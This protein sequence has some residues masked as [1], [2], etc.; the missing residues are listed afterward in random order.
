MTADGLHFPGR[1][2][3]IARLDAAIAGRRGEALAR[4][5]QDAMVALID[6]P[7]VQ[8]PGCVLECFDDHYGRRELYRSPRHGYCVIAMT[9]APGQGTPLHDHD[10]LWCVEGVWHG[11]LQISQH[12]LLARQ[13]ERYRFR[14]AGSVRARPGS[15]GCLIPPHQ[16]HVVRNAGTALA[17]SVHVYEGPMDNCVRFRHDEGDWFVAEAAPLASDRAA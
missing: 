4:A 9:W 12:E 11:E 14:Q 7:A 8:L 16:Y 10:G 15:T 6:D 2:T 3:L 5:V 1:D 13:G 17:V